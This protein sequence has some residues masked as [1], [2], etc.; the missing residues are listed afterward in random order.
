MILTMRWMPCV[1]QDVRP[2]LTF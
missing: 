2:R 1:N